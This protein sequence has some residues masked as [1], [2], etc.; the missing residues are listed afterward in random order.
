MKN[1]RRG[2]YKEKQQSMNKLINGRVNE[3]ANERIQKDE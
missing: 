3:W 2:R 1:E